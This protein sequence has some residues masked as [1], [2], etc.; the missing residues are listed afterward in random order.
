VYAQLFDK[1]GVVLKNLVT[2]VKKNE[3]PILTISELRIGSYAIRVFHDQNS[4]GKLDT[5]LI[6]IPKERFG[7]S[8]NVMGQFGPPAF[9]EQLFMHDSVQEMQ[10]TLFGK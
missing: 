3:D 5:N 8:N 6:G 10:I 1:D 4:N 9:E 2:E 7:F